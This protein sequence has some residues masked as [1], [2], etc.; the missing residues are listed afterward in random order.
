MEEPLEKLCK[1]CNHL[2][3]LHNPDCSFKEDKSSVS[4]CGCIKAQY[5]NTIVSDK[6][7]G[8]IEIHCNSC[9]QRIGFIDST[10]ENIFDFTTLC[11]K[12]ITNFDK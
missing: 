4:S 11:N 3:S 8:W 6:Y 9:G 5:Y 1:N 12:C 10:V 7:I 2:M